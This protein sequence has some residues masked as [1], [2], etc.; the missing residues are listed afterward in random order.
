MYRVLTALLLL[1]L[2]TPCFAEVTVTTGTKYFSVSGK[3]QSEIT[4]NLKA[5]ALYKVKDEP[6]PAFTQSEIKYKYS[7]RSQN[8]RCT[9]TKVVI[10]LNLTY[11][12]P[13]LVNKTDKNTLLWWDAKL[14]RFEEHELI[15][16]D[17]SKKYATML[18]KELKKIKDLDC[19]T[20][21]E[22]VK[23]RVNYVMR[24]M[25]AKQE[26]YDRITDH[27]RKQEKHRGI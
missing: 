13:K 5:N 21:K 14:M 10:N 12:Y 6:A 7:W 26:E 16:G 1:V 17:I 4:A 2:S 15:H 23:S 8:G 24:K 3:R 25:R 11:T 9:I 22:V 27:G 20:M 19:T 18:D